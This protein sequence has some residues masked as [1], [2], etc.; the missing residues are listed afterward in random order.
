MEDERE[1]ALFRKRAKALM[2][3]RFRNLRQSMPAGAIARR[4]AAICERVLSDPDVSKASMVALFWPIGEKKEVD[5]RTV[6]AELRARDVVVAYPAIDPETGVM[7]FRIVDDTSALE[8]S[9]LGF[10]AP[11]LGA[12]EAT[13]LDVV[14]TP[15]LAFDA[16]GHRIGYGAGFYDRTLPCYCPPALAIGVAFDFM[17]A[18]DV[19]NGEGDIPVDRV[20][21]GERVLDAVRPSRDATA[22]AAESGS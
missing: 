6:D 15:G 4:S 7:T 13:G 22:P 8:L 5:L 1:E 18:A 3:R 14:V 10:H 21:T 12:P 2:R 17:L 20:I 19:P 11:P 16:R 9:E